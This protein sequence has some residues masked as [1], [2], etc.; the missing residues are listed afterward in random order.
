MKG[1]NRV[2]NTIARKVGCDRE[3]A[4][5]ILNG[6]AQVNGNAYTA[7]ECDG[8]LTICMNGWQIYQRRL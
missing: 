6:C 3:T 4:E 7:Y 1:T 5:M 2:I 8:I